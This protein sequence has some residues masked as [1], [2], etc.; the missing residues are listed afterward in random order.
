MPSRL[1][2]QV[3]EADSAESLAS[4]TVDEEIGEAADKERPQENKVAVTPKEEDVRYGALEFKTLDK[5][6]ARR[7]GGP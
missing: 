1:I 2:D 4:E 6:V 7:D 5:D 3:C